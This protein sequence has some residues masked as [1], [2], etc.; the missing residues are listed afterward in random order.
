MLLAVKQHDL[1]TDRLNVAMTN[2]SRKE[3][4]VGVGYGVADTRIG[5]EDCVSAFLFHQ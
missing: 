3:H 4:H 2:V 5:T 1:D